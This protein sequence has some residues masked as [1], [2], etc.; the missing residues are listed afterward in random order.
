MFHFQELFLSQ[1]IVIL[2]EL[3]KKVSDEKVTMRKCY[4][5]QLTSSNSI[6]ASLEILI[7]G[8]RWVESTGFKKL[9]VV[10]SYE[11]WQN[12]SPCHQSFCLKHFRLPLSQGWKGGP[13]QTTKTAL[14]TLVFKGPI[15][16]LIKL[17]WMVVC[18]LVF[19]PF[20]KSFPVPFI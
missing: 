8:C 15:Y 4:A 7:V 3:F 19:P 20:N 12:D 14:F 11:K 16:N 2:C 1:Q 10:Y 9:C 17:I 13:L 18:I 6:L 5:S